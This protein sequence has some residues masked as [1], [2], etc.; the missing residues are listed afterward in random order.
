VIL[1]KI[2]LYPLPVFFSI[3]AEV[4]RPSFAFCCGFGTWVTKLEKRDKG[5]Q[6]RERRERGGE[7]ERREGEGEEVV[8][9]AEDGD[10][11]MRDITSCCA[12]RVDTILLSCLTQS[13]AG[14]VLE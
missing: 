7:R 4:L 2:L 11:E 8:R 1:V 14:L 13:S 3:L 5:G 10:E 6:R 9:K 12:C